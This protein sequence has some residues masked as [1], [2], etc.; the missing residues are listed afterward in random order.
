MMSNKA[1]FNQINMI[2]LGGTGCNVITSIFKNKSFLEEIKKNPDYKLNALAIDIADGD[3]K[4]LTETY[5]DVVN[6]M[7]SEGIPQEKIFLRALTIKYNSP[8]T[9]FDFLQRYPEYLKREGLPIKKDYKPWL[10]NKM[11]IPNLAGGVGRMRGLAKAVYALNYYHFSELQTILE[12]FENRIASSTSQPIITMIYGIGGGTGSGIMFDLARHLRKKITSGIPIMGIAV[13]PS[14]N[15][16]ALAKGPSPYMA[17]QEMGKLFDMSITHNNPISLMLFL[18]LQVAVTET[19]EG[20][21][22]KAK[23]QIDVEIRDVLE[24]L[25]SFDLADFLSDIGSTQNLKKNYLNLIGLLKVRFPVEDYIQASNIYVKRSLTYGTLLKEKT[26]FL[27][28]IE[29][30]IDIYFNE[31]VEDYKSHLIS[32]GDTTDNIEKKILGAVKQNRKYDAETN[33]MMKGLERYINSFIDFYN[34]PL[35]TMQFESDTVE[36]SIVERIK[37]VI[38]DLRTVARSEFDEQRMVIIKKDLEASLGAARLFTSM[39]IQFLNQI[40]EFLDFS[41]KSVEVS[42]QYFKLKF[43]YL[44]LS[45][46]LRVS[47][48]EKAAE[49][50]RVVN[51]ELANLLK[52]IST[53]LG[54]VEVEYKLI[55][56]YSATIAGMKRTYENRIRASRIDIEEMET[57][58]SQKSREASELEREI[59]KSKIFKGPKRNKLEREL[60][61]TN[62]YISKIKAT[63]AEKNKEFEKDNEINEY[64]GKIASYPDV[65]GTVWK[66]ITQIIKLNEN[67]NAILSNATRAG[68]FF[69]K[70]LDL[71]EDERLKIL[72]LILKEEEDKLNDPEVIKGIIDIYR[73]KTNLKGIMRLFSSPGFFGLN[74]KYSSD[75]IWAIVSTPIIWD[76]EMEEDLRN[77]LAQYSTVSAGVSVSVRAIQPL[78][79]WT[80]EFMIIAAKASPSDLE[81]YNTI[82]V[83]S[84]ALEEDE[85]KLFRSYMIE[86][87]PSSE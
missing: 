87:E 1:V 5:R 44:E 72:N 78:E 36:S 58:V 45:S 75:K 29:K 4:L 17:L 32:I 27:D 65:T 10:D 40:L 82:E 74:K 57:T 55:H 80:I 31:G 85:M 76:N 12:E 9:L 64:L 83:N 16:D 79:P 59:S 54:P 53:V 66:S 14:N 71:S 18:P 20:T 56:Q 15:D 81:I 39:Q 69:E 67:Y 33:Q 42:K 68:N 22:M 38:E 28:A 61:N 24:L 48:P 11:R 60:Q 23:S 63:I 30:Y 84:M 34:P 13:L 86:E 19:K 46:L 37:N 47:M 49:Y 73:L 43:L 77:Q 35:K 2:G 25:S 21:L 51:E 52:Y 7:V 6:W 62:E 50:E 8:D 41:R 3:I 70:I 26:V